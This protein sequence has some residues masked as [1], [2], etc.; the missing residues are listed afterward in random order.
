MSGSKFLN[1]FSSQRYIAY[2]S[3]EF[4]RYKDWGYTHDEG[5][6]VA[7]VL[8]LLGVYEFRDLSYIMCYD[9]E[10]VLN[11]SNRFW[12]RKYDDDTLF[13]VLAELAKILYDE[14]VVEE[15]DE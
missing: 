10:L 1:W 13:E 15:C 9:D 5:Y 4:Q 12:W 7:R 14:H 11:V 6:A 8:T 2:E 3:D